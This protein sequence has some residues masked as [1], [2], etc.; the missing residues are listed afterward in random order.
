MN[1]EQVM[2]MTSSSVKRPIHTLGTSRLLSFTGVEWIPERTLSTTLG[3]L[4]TY[5][6]F[7]LKTL[8]LTLSF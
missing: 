7:V 2:N 1:Y 6:V 5:S 8:N 4:R 3:W